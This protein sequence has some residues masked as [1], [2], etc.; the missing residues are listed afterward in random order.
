LTNCSKR[1]KSCAA[2]RDVGGSVL[3][4]DQ[5]RRLVVKGK[6]LGRRRLAGIV[7]IVTPDTALVSHAGCKKVRWLADA[8]SWSPRTKAD[9]AALV[10]RLAQENPSW[11]YTRIRG[12][13]KEPGHDVGRNTI[14]AILQ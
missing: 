8:T 3:T 7:G 12:G 1:T 5:H 4:D 13:L 6:V 2:C 10:V 9:L 14:K 11:R